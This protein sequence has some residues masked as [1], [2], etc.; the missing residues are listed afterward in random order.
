VGDDR[1]LKAVLAQV[2]APGVAHQ[3][4]AVHIFH[5]GEHGEKMVH[6]GSPFFFILFIIPF[7]PANARGQKTKKTSFGQNL[8]KTV[9]YNSTE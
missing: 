7:S 4:P 2:L 5:A 1:R 9:W 6:R 3:A 8:S